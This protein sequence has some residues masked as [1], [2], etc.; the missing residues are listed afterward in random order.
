MP[1]HHIVCSSFITENAGQHIRV[2]ADVEE[3]LDVNW[4]AETDPRPDARSVDDRLQAKCI[5]KLCSFCPVEC[6][7]FVT[8][9]KK[10]D[11]GAHFFRDS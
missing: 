5:G 10:W 8:P 4:A 11:R 6:L 3:R 7:G 9:I 2:L 1:I